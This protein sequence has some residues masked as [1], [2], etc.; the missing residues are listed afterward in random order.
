MQGFPNIAWC[1]VRNAS[2]PQIPNLNNN[3]K[4]ASKEA[5]EIY[6]EYGGITTAASVVA[7]WSIINAMFNE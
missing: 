7:T 6:T 3:I 5:A 4:A 2:D 1:S